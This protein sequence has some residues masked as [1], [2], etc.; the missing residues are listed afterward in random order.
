[1]ARLWA[2]ASLAIAPS[3][4]GECRSGTAG[5]TFRA[6]CASFS[7]S[8]FCNAYDAL[9][10]IEL[11]PTGTIPATLAGRRGFLPITFVNKMEGDTYGLELWGDYQVTEWWRLT[12]GYNAL[13][14]H[15]RLAS[16]SLDVGG[17]AGAGNNP[18]YQA[19]LRSSVD[20]PFALN[21]DINV[22]RVA[23]LPSP[24]VPAY[25]EAG[26][27]LGWQPG[28]HLELSVAGVNLLHRRHR[29]FGKASEIPR[30]VAVSARWVF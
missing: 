24:I 8:A 10:S 27:R 21:L 29:E 7:V 15:L 12:A 22:R 6:A 4:R 3:P 19:S 23:A 9:R 14:E 5:G 17:I 16:D 2:W 20:L 13:R 30:H 18:R 11:S 25:G 1:V 28:E 26:A